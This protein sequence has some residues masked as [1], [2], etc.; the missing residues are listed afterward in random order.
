MDLKAHKILR[1][2]SYLL[3][4]GTTSKICI[5]VSETNTQCSDTH[6]IKPGAEKSPE[7]GSD[8]FP[9]YVFSLKRSNYLQC[10]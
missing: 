8:F 3:G 2:T 1:R 9:Q 10:H 7:V 4:C 6:R 5:P